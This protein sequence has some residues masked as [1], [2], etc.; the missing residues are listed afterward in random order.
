MTKPFQG[1]RPFA[2]DVISCDRCAL[3][4]F[5]LHHAQGVAE[6]DS[7]TLVLGESE[8]VKGGDGISNEHRTAFGVK[9]AIGGEQHSIRAKEI[10]PTAYRR[11]RPADGRVIIEQPEI[12][13]RPA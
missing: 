4:G 9:G 7:G 1:P 10:E 8:T 5:H 6:V 11:T 3:S 13:D 12:I 2:Q